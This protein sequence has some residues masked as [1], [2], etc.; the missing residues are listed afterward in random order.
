MKKWG[1]ASI[2]TMALVWAGG[3]SSN[4]ESVGAETSIASQPYWVDDMKTESSKTRAETGER[5]ILSENL[6]SIKFIGDYPLK[7]YYDCSFEHENGFVESGAIF[8]MFEIADKAGWIQISER[9]FINLGDYSDFEFTY[10][11]VTSNE[12]VIRYPQ[13]LDNSSIH[14]EKYQK[15]DILVALEEVEISDY[16]NKTLFILSPMIGIKVVEAQA[17]WYLVEVNGYTGKEALFLHIDETSYSKFSLVYREALEISENPETTAKPE[18]PETTAKPENS[19]TTA[20]PEIPSETDKKEDTDV[21]ETYYKE[22]TTL[23]FN[24]ISWGIRSTP[25][26]TN[27]NRVGQIDSSNSLVQLGKYLGNG[28]YEIK[29]TKYYIRILESEK[30]YFSNVLF[31]VGD[32]LI[33]RANHWRLRSSNKFVEDNIVK[34]IYTGEEFI[35]R[36]VLPNQW[37]TVDYKGEKYFLNI[38]LTEVKWFRK[39]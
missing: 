22:G 9:N 13:N 17:P 8:K 37:Y 21:V 39:K 31:K 1:S 24:G 26:I 4:V 11:K 20:K 28:W 10:K 15:N 30:K 3:I 5:D 32:T 29:D 12:S 6:E 36:K 34:E 16:Y 2:L 33:L 19:E 18:N 38:P 14:P 25:I 35:I 7:T 23:M 27:E